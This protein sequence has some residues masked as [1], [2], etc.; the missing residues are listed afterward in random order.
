MV[1]AK[2]ISQSPTTEG[3]RIVRPTPITPA[4]VTRFYA[5]GL[6]HGPQR[7]HALLQ[8]LAPG[9]PTTSSCPVSSRSDQNSSWSTK[10]TQFF[11]SVVPTTPLET[12]DSQH[13][14]TE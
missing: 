9:M 2:S 3:P 11:R 12:S 14:L 13:L 8:I 1:T 6:A 5:L 10:E 4:T 7:P